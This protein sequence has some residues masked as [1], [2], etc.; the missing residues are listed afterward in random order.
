MA[1]DFPEQRVVAGAGD[2]GGGVML[3]PIDAERFRAATPLLVGRGL[4]PLRACSAA[5]RSRTSPRSGANASGAGIGHGSS[6]SLPFDSHATTCR[7]DRNV[8]PA[9][10]DIFPVAGSHH[11]RSGLLRDRADVSRNPLVASREKDTGSAFVR[12]QP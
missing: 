7:V 1:P 8:S 10:M 12:V 11:A 6:G 2:H 5:W 3:R 4:S 9:H